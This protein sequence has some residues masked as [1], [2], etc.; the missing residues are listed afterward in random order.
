MIKLHDKTFE[1]Y[2]SEKEIKERVQLLAQKILED[3]KDQTPVFLGVL[4]G[5]FMFCADLLKNYSATCEVSF[6]KL[7]SYEKTTSTGNIN[8]LIGLNQ[9]LKNRTVIVLEDI[10]DTGNTIVKLTSLLEEHKV[11]EYKVATLFL[12]PEVYKKEVAI[13]YVGFKIPN[14]FIVGYGLDYD[15]LGRNLKEVYKLVE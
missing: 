8:Q 12:K 9:D 5:A 7:A 13:D 1:T 4:N 2:I 14:Q 10:V 15:Q 3:Y 11:K 6:V